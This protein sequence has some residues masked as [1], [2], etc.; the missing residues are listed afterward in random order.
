MAK[1]VFALIYVNTVYVGGGAVITD[2]AAALVRPFGV[3]A[4]FIDST[5]IL[6]FLTFV[7]I[8]AESPVDQV[9]ARQTQARE[10][11]LIVDTRGLVSATSI[12]H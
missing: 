1:L 6:Q 2:F 11:T 3:P 5:G 10:G 7:Y 9:E 4:L 12:I 8:L